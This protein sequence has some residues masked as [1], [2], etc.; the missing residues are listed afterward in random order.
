MPWMESHMLW[1]EKRLM[2][3]RQASQISVIKCCLL[4]QLISHHWDL[5]IL[6]PRN[7]KGQKARAQ[8]SRRRLM[9]LRLMVCEDLH[10]LLKPSD[11]A[12]Q[13][14]KAMTHQ[15]S[16][17]SHNGGD[18]RS[19]R[20]SLLRPH[21]HHAHVS[22][23]QVKV[24]NLSRTEIPEYFSHLNLISKQ[25]SVKEAKPFLHPWSDDEPWVGRKKICLNNKRRKSASKDEER[26][27][28]NLCC[29]CSQLNFLLEIHQLVKI[30][31][32]CAKQSTRD[33][34][35]IRWR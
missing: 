21:H 12:K 29:F 15:M 33:S 25:K 13:L 5:N 23:S 16:F 35:T 27:K 3:A 14:F 19:R 8:I 11:Y 30:D 34:T 9:M 2:Y 7:Y 32:Y 20:G 6:R 4:F 17:N 1:N 26:I 22:T 28:L 24:V 18:Y 31:F 10:C